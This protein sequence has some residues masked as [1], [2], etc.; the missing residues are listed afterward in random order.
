MNQQPL[1]IVITALLLVI[2]LGSA[3]AWVSPDLLE[4]FAVKLMARSMALR[5]SRQAYDV[6]YAGTL[7]NWRGLRHWCAEKEEIETEL[8]V[9]KSS[10]RDG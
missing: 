7:Q 8:M 4:R 10:L 1:N 3:A 2:A 9:V 6:E 5:L